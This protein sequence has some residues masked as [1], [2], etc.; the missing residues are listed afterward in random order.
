MLA[1]EMAHAIIDNFMKLR[2]P[3]ATAEILARYVDAHLLEE[4]KQ[5]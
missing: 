2:L 5:Y 1:H 4:V 3:R